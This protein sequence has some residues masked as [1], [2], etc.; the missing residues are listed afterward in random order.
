MAASS[1]TSAAPTSCATDG[2]HREHH[3]SARFV[4]QVARI[5]DCLVR[6]VEHLADTLLEDAARAGERD[7]A[8]RAVEQAR[9]D[10]VLQPQQLLAERWLSDAD[11]F[12]RAADRSG[13]GYAQERFEM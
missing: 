6:G 8:Q 3:L 12:R 2:R 9:A 11:R 5:R 4:T 7:H 13:L 10:L 1:F